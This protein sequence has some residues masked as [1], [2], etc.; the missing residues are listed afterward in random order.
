M[1]AT[2]GLAL[3]IAA[4]PAAAGA[5]RVHAAVR[6]M[7]KAQEGRVLFT[8]LWNGDT[9]SG[10][11]R[12]YAARLYEVFFELPAHIRDEAR[13]TG[14][15]P[16]VAA[17]AANFGLS[18]AAI[19][20]LLTVM[21]TEPRMPRLL[22]LKA[23]SGEIAEVDAAALDAFVKSRGTR[24]K[25]SGW[26]GQ[27]LPDFTLP[28]IGGGQL[29]WADLRGQPTLVYV[30]LTRCPVCRRVG[31]RL[32]EL[33][34]R[35]AERGL[36]LVGL[37]ADT[38]LGLD[39]PESEREAWLRE[40]KVAYPNASLDAASRA[41]LGQNIFPAFFLVG[42]DGK[43]VELVLNERTLEELTALA[44]KLLASSPKKD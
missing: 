37:N 19:D 7:M 42:R 35:F 21:T 36:R 11:E 24:V 22:R 27:A 8:E 33:Q 25:V 3:T 14:R 40:Q 38:V 26:A 20:L 34:T 6:E 39:V 13:A 5:E 28:A 15:P 12:E 23:E 44:E 41:A 2:L 32:V 1:L 9:L 30:W 18:R 10:P 29:V 16:E 4:A 17:L 31:P 43:V